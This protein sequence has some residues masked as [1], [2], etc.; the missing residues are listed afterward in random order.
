MFYDMGY[1]TRGMAKACDALDILVLESNH[2]DD[3][4]RY[5][6][7]APWLQKRIA[8]RFGH[9]SNPEAARFAQAMV[10]KDMNHL[11]L[12]HLSENCNT[13]RVALDCM[14]VAIKGTKFQGT[15]TAAQQDAVVGPFMPG[16][17]KAEAPTQFSLF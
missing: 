6:P 16:A 1:V 14:R 5:G 13:P 10:T 3:M 2:D 15:L 4:L 7:Y 17:K 11:V 8:G 9:L 12:A